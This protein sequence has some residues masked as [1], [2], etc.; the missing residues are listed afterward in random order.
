[1]TKDEI[2]KS[3]N[4]LKESNA[5]NVKKAEDTIQ[6]IDSKEVSDA[7]AA[8]GITGLTSELP[9]QKDVEKEVNKNE[10]PIVPADKDGISKNGGE[11]DKLE[12][13][14]VEAERKKED[15]GMKDV[16][17]VSD[18][19]VEENA[20]STTELLNQLKEAAAREEHY[21]AEVAKMKALCEEAIKL[22]GQELTQ[23]HAKQMHDVFE[24][25]VKK[26]EDLEAQMNEAVAKNEKLYKSAQK[27]Y[28]GSTRLNKI[29]L[30]AV[31]KAQPEKKMTRYMSASARALAAFNK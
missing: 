31:K 6:N 25:V 18:R 14:K 12:N 26:G 22:Q 4:A 23:L 15:N 21:K 5:L 1:M 3:I 11:S 27:L 13:G 24:A 8:Q 7:K 20:E 16:I 19:K 17:N 28:E 9:T 30:E 29:L 2:L 10:G